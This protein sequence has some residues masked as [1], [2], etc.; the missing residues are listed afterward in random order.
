[1]TLDEKMPSFR[2]KPLDTDGTRPV[3]HRVANVHTGSVAAKVGLRNASVIT[4]VS[5]EHT[6]A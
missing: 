3:A 6:T 5:R 2:V 1:M 4:V